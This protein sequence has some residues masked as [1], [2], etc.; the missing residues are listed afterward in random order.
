MNLVDEILSDWSIQRPDIDCSGKAIVCRILH[1]YSTFISTLEKSLKPFGITPNVF[2]VLVTIRRKGA[3]AEV[4]VKKILEEALVTSG[5]MS[6]LLN[7]LMDAGLITKRKGMGQEDERSTYVKLTAKGLALIDRAMEVQA[8]S[9]RRLTENLTNPE[10]KQLAEL[11][12]KLLPEEHPYV[13][14]MQ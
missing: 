14:N 13:E 6:N 9:E 1:C 4:T 3:D 12:K 11:L 7:K 8:A 2:S 10:K 5:A